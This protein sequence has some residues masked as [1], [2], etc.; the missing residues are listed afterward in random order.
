[1]RSVGQVEYDLTGKPLRMMGVVQDVTNAFVLNQRLNENESRY[2]DLVENASD[3]ILVFDLDGNLEEINHAGEI[4]L[5]YSKVEIRGMQVQQI[6]PKGILDFVNQ[7]YLNIAGGNKLKNFE[8]NVQCKNGEI[9]EVE[10]RPTLIDLG[11]RKVIRGIFID[12][13]ERKLQEKEKQEA[14]NRQRDI[15][16]REVHHRIKNHLQGVSGVFYQYIEQYPHLAEPLEHAISQVKSVAVVYG[17]QG[18]DTQTKA[19]LCALTSAIAK[20]NELLW[21]TPV[22]IISTEQL[23]PCQILESEA[24]PLALILN[25]LISNAIK[26]GDKA[27]GISIS[28]HQDTSINKTVIKIFNSGRLPAGFNFKHLNS[29]GTGLKLVLSLLP[30]NNAHIT[31]EQQDDMVITQLELM[32]PI[33]TFELVEGGRNE[34]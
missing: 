27:N 6:H 19:Y 24:V 18:R 16:V 9:L 34:F 13:T 29:S 23:I 12:I 17:L 8:T 31:W 3:A 28:C 14:Q 5:G 4:L 32:P 25:E 2:R 22:N 20:E 30:K 11:Q 1:M 33:L 15:L 21:Q 26:H 7:Q 10:I